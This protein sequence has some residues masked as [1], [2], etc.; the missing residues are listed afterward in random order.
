MNQPQKVPGCVYSMQH[1]EDAVALHR[2]LYHQYHQTQTDSDNENIK[3]GHITFIFSLFS[4]E[5]IFP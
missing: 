3:D 2:L 5:Q 4:R 1:R